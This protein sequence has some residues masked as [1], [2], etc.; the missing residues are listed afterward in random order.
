MNQLNLIEELTKI[1]NN[2]DYISDLSNNAENLKGITNNLI[3]ILSSI[4]STFN[5]KQ[6]VLKTDK[7]TEECKRFYN[8]IHDKVEGLENICNRYYNLNVTLK[9][10]LK[11]SI[12]NEQVS[13]KTVEE[14]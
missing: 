14:I 10:S 11:S 6:I 8:D 12:V 5:E 2:L 7:F 1:N 4:D 3:E 13:L 9:D